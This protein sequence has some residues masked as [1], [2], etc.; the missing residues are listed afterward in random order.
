MSDIREP[1]AE[2][3]VVGYSWKKGAASSGN[4]MVFLSAAQASRYLHDMTT[5]G[6]YELTNISVHRLVGAEWEEMAFHPA[7]PATV[8]VHGG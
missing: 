5:E 8:E 7:T 4:Q 3:Y 6:E 1:P 2:L